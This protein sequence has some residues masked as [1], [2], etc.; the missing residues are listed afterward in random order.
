[1]PVFMPLSEGFRKV[2]T[3]TYIEGGVTLNFFRFFNG[4]NRRTI[5]TVI[6]FVLILAMVLMFIPGN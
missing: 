1:M 6:V 3:V 4:K 5:A 2:L